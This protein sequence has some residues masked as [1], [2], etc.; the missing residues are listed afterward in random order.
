MALEK[1]ALNRVLTCRRSISEGFRVS[2]FETS[3]C[4]QRGRFS[5]F[6][7]TFKN[8]EFFFIH[9]KI[10]PMNDLNGTIRLNIFVKLNP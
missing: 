2:F 3:D 8:D 4:A 5:I 10:G 7:R 6:Q 1:F 9:C